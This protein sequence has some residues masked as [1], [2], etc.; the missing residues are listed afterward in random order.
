MLRI[1]H[2]HTPEWKGVIIGATTLGQVTV[3]HLRFISELKRRMTEASAK[4]PLPP[5]PFY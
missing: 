4:M 5:D 2:T 1:T 3:R